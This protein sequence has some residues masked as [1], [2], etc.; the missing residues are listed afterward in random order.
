VVQHRTEADDKSKSIA[1][2]ADISRCL[3]SLGEGGIRT[4]TRTTARHKRQ[5]IPGV[6]CTCPARLCVVPTLT[7]D[8]L[9]A[10]LVVGHG[11]ATAA[12]VRGDTASDS[13]V[14]GSAD[15][16][17]VS[18]GLRASLLGARQRPCLW[19]FLH[20]SGEGDGYP[21]STDLSWIAMAKW[22]CRTSDRHIASAWIKC[23]SSAKCTC[24]EFFPLMRRITIRRARTWH[25]R[26]MRPFIEQSNDLAP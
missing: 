15:H 25:Y 26:T 6:R 22:L 11:P 7:F 21:R 14:A 13:R 12:V 19:T 20:V 2:V 17:G 16:R 5:S 3:R 1:N 10:F 8:R 4:V 18:L 24:G 23:S 9:F